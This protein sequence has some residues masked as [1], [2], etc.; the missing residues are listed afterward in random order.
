MKSEQK[1]TS[2]RYFQLRCKKSFAHSG[3][4]VKC[5]LF[6]FLDTTANETSGK[7]KKKRENGK[8]TNVQKWFFIP[9][10]IQEN[11]YI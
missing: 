4:F 2:P 6:D 5:A 1:S 7:K 9:S 11:K 10:H 8:D 3:F